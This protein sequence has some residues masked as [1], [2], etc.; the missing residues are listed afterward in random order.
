MVGWDVG[1]GGVGRDGSGVA[2][3]SC[4]VS[5]TLSSHQVILLLTAAGS[6]L[7]AFKSFLPGFLG[8][9]SVGFITVG[10]SGKLGSIKEEAFGVSL[11]MILLNSVLSA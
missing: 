7:L 6:L 4:E 11:P 5:W 8:Q 9:D 2:A 10:D 3:S 1:V